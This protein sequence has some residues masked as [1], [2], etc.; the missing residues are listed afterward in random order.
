MGLDGGT[1]GEA[2]AAQEGQHGSLQITGSI[3]RKRRGSDGAWKDATF[4]IPRA[5]LE[6]TKRVTGMLTLAR[7]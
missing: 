2:E 6:A 7:R 3:P 5:A 4:A 1:A